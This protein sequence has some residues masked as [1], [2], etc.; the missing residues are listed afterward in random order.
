MPAPAPIETIRLSQEDRDRLVT[1]KRRTGVPN[2]NTLCRWAFCRS[3][4]E[5][6]P[7]P[8]VPIPSDSNAEFSWQTFGGPN[9]E[10]FLALL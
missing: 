5:P 3:L 9:A 2:W 6:T 1:L 7:P 4:A 10:V 8:N